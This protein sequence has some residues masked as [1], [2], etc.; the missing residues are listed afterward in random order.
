MSDC[1]FLL[2]LSHIYVIWCKITASL[3]F[4][5]HT[6]KISTI[7]YKETWKRYTY[8]ILSHWMSTSSPWSS[9]SSHIFIFF[10]NMLIKICCD[11]SVSWITFLGRPTCCFFGVNSL[12][13]G[14]LVNCF[15]MLPLLFLRWCFCWILF[16]WP[17]SLLQTWY[18]QINFHD[19]IS[20]ITIKPLVFL[21]DQMVPF[22]KRFNLLYSSSF[23]AG[24]G[25]ST[26]AI[27][28]LSRFTDPNVLFHI[29][30]F[31]SL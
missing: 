7:K 19:N 24:Q 25:K 21:W 18:V 9:F 2:I 17:P 16:V 14:V 22:C 12:T 1:I 23:H 13:P 30:L 4:Y 15:F 8:Y 31:V 11:W 29:L 27:V 6:D 20:Y 28:N 3:Y 5:L 10:R 26:L